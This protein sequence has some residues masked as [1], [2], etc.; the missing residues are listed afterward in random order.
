MTISIIGTGYV[1]LVTGAVFADFGHKVY[2]VDIDENKIESLKKGDV[3]FYEPGLEEL[4]RRNIIQK[5]LVFTTD[6]S[7]AVPF[8]KITFICVGTPE[9]ENGEANLS[10]LF[11]ATRETAKHLKGYTL[12]AIKSTVPIGVEYELE[13]IVTE[14]T[15]SEFEFASCPEFLREGSAVEDTLRPDRVVI[16][17]KSQKGI[18]ILLDLYKHINGQRVVS[19]LKSAQMIKYASNSFLAT[20]ISFANAIAN[21]CEK[22]GA[23]VEMVLTGVG[24]DKRIGRGFLYPGVGFGGSCFPKDLAA[25]IHLC[26]KAGVNLEILEAVQKIN[27]NQINLF[28]DKIINAVGEVEG[29]KLAILGL[30]FKPNTDDIR[31][32]PAMKIIQRLLEKGAQIKA[33]DPAAT[34]NAQKIF[35]DKVKF[36]SSSY[37][38]LE[39]AEALILI[40]DWNEFK[41]LDLEKV[42]KIMARP[43]IIDGRNIYD[44]KK[45]KILGFTYQGVGRN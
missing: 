1:G 9:G 18:K 36:Y 4:V 12:I 43:I 11:Q 37:S 31:E 5:R 7:K 6:Y 3:P 45:V 40:T 27:Q 38:A 21:A 23:D 39:D 34:L 20:K 25:F 33:Y 29:K 22:L 14:Q 35:G 26:K 16:G 30:S 44:P 15:I 28:M 13:K 17:C 41:E 2:C 24:L 10:Y 32:A 42:K 19:D 8:S